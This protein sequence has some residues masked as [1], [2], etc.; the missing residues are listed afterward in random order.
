MH[1]PAFRKRSLLAGVVEKTGCRPERRE[2]VARRNG[3]D[4]VLKL[5]P[6]RLIGVST[7]QRVESPKLQPA[8]ALPVCDLDSS[9]QRPN[10]VGFS[11][12]IRQLTVDS[13][14]LGLEIAL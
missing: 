1:A 10:S 3:L 11:T 7:G 13:P 8:R 12:A 6:R 9:A 2:I 14:Q 4:E 5:L